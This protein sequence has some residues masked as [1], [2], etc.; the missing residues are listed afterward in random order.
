M[1]KEYPKLNFP[2]INL[3]VKRHEDGTTLSV[4]SSPRRCYLRLTPEEWVRRHLVEYLHAEFNIPTIE[5]VEE[6]PVLLNGQNQR[7]DLVVVRD[8][9][10][11]I[12]AECKAPDVKIS[13]ETLAQAVRYNSIVGARYIILTNG[14]THLCFEIIDGEYKSLNSFPKIF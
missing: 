14:L 13:R 7:A 9:K 6:Y 12:L 4:W 11:L 5:M 10:A 3:R 8:T 2:P 1:P